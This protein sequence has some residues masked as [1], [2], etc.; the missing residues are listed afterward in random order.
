[1]DQPDA[2]QIRKGENQVIKAQWIGSQLLARGGNYAI[3][4]DRWQVPES[5]TGTK[6]Y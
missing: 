3:R 4:S 6:Y 2:F 1:M 5:V